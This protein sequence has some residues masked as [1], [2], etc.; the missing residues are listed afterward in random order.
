M[1]YTVP[2]SDQIGSSFLFTISEFVYPDGHIC[3]TS[4]ILSKNLDELDTI[5]Y[6]NLKR[7]AKRL[8]IH[9]RSNMNKQMLSEH[10]KQLITFE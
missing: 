1:N 7:M 4:L 9:G 5:P 2:V 3:P 8:N 6:F 10:I